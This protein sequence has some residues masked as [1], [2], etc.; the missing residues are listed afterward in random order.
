MNEPIKKVM[1]SIALPESLG[2]SGRRGI[3]RAA[4]ELA[5]ER[6]R[7]GRRRRLALGAAAI[8]L[9]GCV[10]LGGALWNTEAMAS[11]RQALDFVPGI[12]V[13]NKTDETERRLVLKEP[14]EW[15]EGS[16]QMWV[17]SIS[18]DDAMTYVVMNGSGV[19]LADAITLIQNGEETVLPRAMST[20]ATGEW[21]A[22]F[23][24]KGKAKLE[25][26]GV[27]LVVQTEDEA[28]NIRIPLVLEQ[29][30][31]YASYEEL[32][33][34]VTA[35]GISV[36]AAVTKAG[37]KTRIYLA[38][39][40]SDEF[41]ISS[42]GV[43]EWYGIR[44]AVHDDRGTEYEVEQVASISSPGDDFYVRLPQEEERS[45]TLTI[46]AI[47]VSYADTA[48]VALPVETR[49][50]LNMELELAGLPL[51]VT[52]T[53][54]TDNG[55]MKVYVDTHYDGNA[56]RSLATFSLEG[57][58]HMAKLDEAMLT[59]EFVEFDVGPGQSKAQ[60]TLGRP[61]VVVRGPWVMQFGGKGAAAAE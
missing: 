39:R 19:R 32:G 29:A 28:R 23:W 12:G 25:E 31:A 27:T 52:G 58:S 16:G 9:A 13:V 22:S 36:T 34:T 33:P 47:A 20:R 37:D 43:T 21:R 41:R 5:R 8:A 49:A 26:G 6:R 17:T 57:Q 30:E 15:E 44:L 40:H 50:D 53:E 14:V 56:P 60:L 54:V 11:L 3:A 46:P 61:E 18:A 4:D 1:S 51:T 35:N 59:T 2:E 38:S 48:S 7:R 10:A 55:T 24:S 45:Y 42:Y